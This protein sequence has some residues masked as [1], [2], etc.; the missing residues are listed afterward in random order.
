L[1]DG[2]AGLVATPVRVADPAVA[3]LLAVGDVIDL[4]A[5]SPEAGRATVVAAEAPV[6]AVP[7]PSP[8]D[9]VV[10]GALVLVAVPQAEAMA[11]S[12]A[13]VRSVVS[14]VLRR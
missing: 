14:V 3:R 5:V 11:L 1:L 10:G 7:D 8:E 4:V 6:V 2:Y 9:G 13:T 12:E